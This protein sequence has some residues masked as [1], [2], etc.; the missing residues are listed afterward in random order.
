MYFVTNV[1]ICPHS[2][3]TDT[4]LYLE[5]CGSNQT[6]VLL[7]SII[8]VGTCPKQIEQTRVLVETR[9]TDRAKHHDTAVCFRKARVREEG[10]S[11]AKGP[12]LLC[13]LLLCCCCTGVSVTP[14][15]A[16]QF[17]FVLFLRSKFSPASRPH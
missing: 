6:Y 15:A 12:A 13:L 9:H 11:I 16:C 7:T 3:T 17:V 5:S 4:Y 10:E 14:L 1:T 2:V 8:P